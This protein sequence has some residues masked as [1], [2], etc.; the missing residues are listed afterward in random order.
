MFEVRARSQCESCCRGRWRRDQPGER[1]S[2]RLWNAS[3][4]SSK[5]ETIQRQKMELAFFA[6]AFFSLFRPLLRP[7]P[8][9]LSLSLFSHAPAPA[10]VSLFH[11]SF[12]LC[13]V[14][15]YSFAPS[16]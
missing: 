15:F 6:L 3:S 13:F 7:P 11:Y 4:S 2:E 8:L 9:S 10:L 14:T 1:E 16:V 5:K 12:V